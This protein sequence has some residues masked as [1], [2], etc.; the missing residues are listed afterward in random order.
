MSSEE[1]RLLILQMVADQKISAAEAAQLLQALEQEG[2]GKADQNQA[3][4]T[5]PPHVD[6]T[7]K[8]AERT[9]LDAA[10]TISENARQMARDAAEAARRE[11]LGGLFGRLLEQFNLDFYDD[12]RTQFDQVMEGAFTADQPTL[13]LHTGNGKLHLHG[14]DQ[15]GYKVVLTYKVR[16]VATEAEARERAQQYASFEAG[17]E[18]L[19]LRGQDRWLSSSGITVSAEI[20]LPRD[21]RYHLKGRTGNGSLHALDLPLVEGDLTSGNG[22]VRVE[23]VTGE[24]L[25][26]STGNGSITI[27]ADLV[28]C[29]AQTGNGGLKFRLTG[30]NGQQIDLATG[31]GSAV[32]DLSSLPDSHGFR[33]DAT[34]GLGGIHLDRNDLVLEKDVRSV[35]HKH[36]L[37]RSR[38]YDE[39]GQRVEI[40]VRTGLGSMTVK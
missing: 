35:G 7:I 5:A 20:W 10:H 26:A 38:N 23:G 9:V 19:R 32:V 3:W 33:L 29:S 6:R 2:G 15:P 34:T 12:G 14:W 31:N 11:N 24:R 40:K 21:R 27:A 28:R 17:P 8:D 25:K 16:G 13:D 4:S 1:E 39:V 36:L 18:G 37:A 22:A 30:T